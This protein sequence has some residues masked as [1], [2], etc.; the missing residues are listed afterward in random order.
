[1]SSVMEKT[2][3]SSSEEPNVVDAGGDSGEGDTAASVEITDISGTVGREVFQFKVTLNRT[4]P[5]IWGRIQ[6][7][8]DYKF[9][10]LHCAIQN[11]MGWNDDCHFQFEVKNPVNGSS[12]KIGKP[13]GLEGRVWNLDEMN[14]QDMLSLRRMYALPGVKVDPVEKVYACWKVPLSKYLNPDLKYQIEYKYSN[15]TGAGDCHW[16]HEVIFEGMLHV[17]SEK[18]TARCISGE[19]ACPPDESMDTEDFAELLVN[20]KTKEEDRNSE[21]REEMKEWLMKKISKEY[22]PEFFDPSAVVFNNPKMWLEH[23]RA[24]PYFCSTCSSSSAHAHHH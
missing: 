21:Q 12:V 9:W 20:L 13:H 1:M 22:D 23:K 2:D 3:S 6:V 16:V 24:N 19:R 4:D 10:G 11:S 18:L 17:G 14:C 15:P 7:P 8:S 5:P